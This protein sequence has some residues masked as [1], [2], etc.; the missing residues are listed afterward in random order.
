MVI[1][2]EFLPLKLDSQEFL[3]GSVLRLELSM[4]GAWVQSLVGE[5]DPTHYT[6][7]LHLKILLLRG[8][9]GAAE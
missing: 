8:S 6:K 7:T 2:S 3:V 5:L 9:P 1:I 4:Q